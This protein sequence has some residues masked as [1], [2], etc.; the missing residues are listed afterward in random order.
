MGMQIY[1]NM[2][3]LGD[4]KPKV[5]EYDYVDKIYTAKIITDSVGKLSG[6]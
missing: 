1:F 5:I 3:D 2:S 6:Q 4:K